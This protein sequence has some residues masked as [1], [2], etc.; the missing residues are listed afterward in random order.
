M[1]AI[2]F[3]PILLA[4]TLHL[5][6]A[7]TQ[8]NWQLIYLGL[9]RVNHAE[10]LVAAVCRE[11]N[12]EQMV[13]SSP[14]PGDLFFCVCSVPSSFVR[15]EQESRIEERLQFDVNWNFGGGN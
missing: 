4:P 15:A 1:M 7:I 10:S 14:Y 12:S 13:I 3:L 9:I 11:A 6:H 8:F 2:Y 5:F